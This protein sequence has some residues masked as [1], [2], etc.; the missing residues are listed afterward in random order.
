MQDHTW[1]HT[2]VHKRSPYLI[3]S[4]STT[5]I[6]Y[7]GHGLNTWNIVSLGILYFK[8]IQFGIYWQFTYPTTLWRPRHQLLCT[9][10]LLWLSL[11][12]SCL[13]CFCLA[14]NFR[15]SCWPFTH[16]HAFFSLFIFHFNTVN[17]VSLKTSR[18]ASAPPPPPRIPLLLPR[19]PSV[20]LLHNARA[21]G[22]FP[23]C[24]V[25][26]YISWLIPTF[27]TLMA[28]F[29]SICALERAPQ[30]RTAA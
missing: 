10:T 5:C 26:N 27:I 19:L 23:S 7:F 22:A 21:S 15:L 14:G 9:Q 16:H 4:F 1:I 17:F 29:S 28:T 11:E 8:E 18:A 30:P 3:L 12:I 2:Y 24:C 13:V 20:W 25:L 6:I